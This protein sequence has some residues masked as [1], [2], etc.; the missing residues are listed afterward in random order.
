MIKRLQKSC[1]LFW[2]ALVIIANAYGY[3]TALEI[4]RLNASSFDGFELEWSFN[5]IDRHSWSSLGL[6][7]NDSNG[8][9]LFLYGSL[10]KNN[11]KNAFFR[12]WR[13]QDEKVSDVHFAN[14]KKL[15]T[16]FIKQ[17]IIDGTASNNII[18]DSVENVTSYFS[19]FQM[20][21]KLKD[22]GTDPPLLRLRNP[23]PYQMFLR[24]LV[25]FNWSCE[26]N[27]ASIVDSKLVISDSSSSVCQEIN[28][29]NLTNFNWN[30]PDSYSNGVYY[31]QII[32]TTNNEETFGSEIRPLIISDESADTDGDGYPDAVELA[33]GSDPNDPKDIPLIIT[34][35]EV[36]PS[37]FKELQ[38]FNI[39][40]ANR[41]ER[42]DW[43][44]IG[45]LPEGM[46]LTSG[47]SLQGRPQNTGDY[48][49]AVYVYDQRGKSDE[50]TLYMEVLKPAPSS[51]RF[52]NGS[53]R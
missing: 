17:T 37:A 45:H 50:K 16:N 4:Q 30:I 22:W 1:R 9:T 27:I 39:L 43:E 49:F 5:P 47:G 11:H 52:G 18:T 13:K 3:D 15:S 7:S 42:L 40:K 46:I 33:R 31:W 48:I 53:F 26:I 29:N 19:C 20:N 34:S 51:V 24:G 2:A 8:N 25:G 44:L 41:N 28:V 23:D 35:S 10:A 38:Y 21:F 6:T 32:L 12:I 36:C 14:V